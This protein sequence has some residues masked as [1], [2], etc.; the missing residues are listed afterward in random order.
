VEGCGA[1]TY[2]IPLTTSET[3]VVRKD[4]IGA[5]SSVADPAR[6]TTILATP[7]AISPDQSDQIFSSIM[8]SLSVR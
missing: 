1:V 7:G 8:Q 3:L 6:V 4:M 5:L 2:Y